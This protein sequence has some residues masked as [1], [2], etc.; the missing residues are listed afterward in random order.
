[1]PCLNGAGP[2][3]GWSERSSRMAGGLEQRKPCGR[4]RPGGREATQFV[5][6]T[7]AWVMALPGLHEVLLMVMPRRWSGNGHGR[8]AARSRQPRA[9]AARR[10]TLMMLRAPFPRRATMPPL[11]PDSPTT[12]PRALTRSR[13]LSTALST[14]YSRVAA[15]AFAGSWLWCR[16]ASATTRR[17]TGLGPGSLIRHYVAGFLLAELTEEADARSALSSGGTAVP[18]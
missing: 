18:R 10:T 16:W 2:S 4:P 6:R 3:T 15:P 13:L 7:R 5:D 12:E 1:V 14:S 9:S 17:G 8:R 11:T